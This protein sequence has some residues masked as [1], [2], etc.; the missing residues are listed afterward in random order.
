MI[1]WRAIVAANKQPLSVARQRTAVHLLAVAAI[2]VVDVDIGVRPKR[3]AAQFVD[4]AYNVAVVRQVTTLFRIPGVSFTCFSNLANCFLA[5]AQLKTVV[6]IQKRRRFAVAWL[7]RF[8]EG[9]CLIGG[10]RLTQT[11][12]ALQLH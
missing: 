6:A 7:E 9:K 4:P 5:C 2:N 12:C 10:S 3:H 8:Y 1:S 11:S